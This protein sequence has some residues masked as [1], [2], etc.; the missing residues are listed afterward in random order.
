MSQSSRTYS[1]RMLRLKLFIP[2]CY[3]LMVVNIGTFAE[4]LTKGIV[5]FTLSIIQGTVKAVS[6]VD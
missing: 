5:C 1:N 4:H 3:L 2:F 6:A